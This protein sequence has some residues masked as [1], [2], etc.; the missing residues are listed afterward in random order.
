MGNNTPPKCLGGVLYNSDVNYSGR[1]V[2][3]VGTSAGQL[4]AVYVLTRA[5]PAFVCHTVATGKQVIAP[6]A[7][8]VV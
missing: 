5:E 3:N 7:L 1:V 2:V 6:D 4:G 8:V